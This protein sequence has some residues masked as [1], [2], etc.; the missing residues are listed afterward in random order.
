MRI[1]I[2]ED[3]PL[4]SKALTRLL[5]IS[6]PQR[7]KRMDCATDGLEALQMAER[8]SYDLILMDIN[9]PMMDGLTAMK[10]IRK[11]RHEQ[12][13]IMISA[14]SDYEHLRGAMQNSAIDYIVKPYSA[15]T[16]KEALDRVLPEIEPQDELYGN[17]GIVEQLRYILD[18]EYDKPWTLEQ[19]AAEVNMNK[20]YMGRIF[21]DAEGM[22]VM[23]YL[24][25]VRIMRAKELLRKGMN[26]NET[27]QRVG[28]EDPSYFGRVFRQETG[29]S[30]LHY[31]RNAQEIIDIKK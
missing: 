4:E 1:L 27:A 15:Q 9:L 17:R 28:I 31:V 11:M 29:V 22:S 16:L 14:Y 8:E 3:E 19:L 2:V 6:Y 24:K 21:R 10:R 26:V 5:E 18:K 13:F 23:N 30:P 20:T 25:A 7:F 12:R